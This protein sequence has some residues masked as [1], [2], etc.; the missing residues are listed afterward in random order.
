MERIRRIGIVNDDIEHFFSPETK[1]SGSNADQNTPEIYR[2]S[3]S[4]LQTWKSNR[5]PTPCNIVLASS[6]ENQIYESSQS[7]RTN[8]EQRHLTRL[9]APSVRQQH[10][11]HHF[12]GHPLT[13]PTQHGLVPLSRTGFHHVFL[14]M[15]IAH[16]RDKRFVAIRESKQLEGRPE[17]RVLHRRGDIWRHAFRGECEG[18]SEEPLEPCCESGRQDGEYVCLKCDDV[19][20]RNGVS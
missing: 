20:G 1:I 17:P 3:H 19:G 6:A 11:R 2:R 16:A 7:G 5:D 4:V 14:D 9:C 12:L 13:Q 8:S 15:L 10:P 18:R